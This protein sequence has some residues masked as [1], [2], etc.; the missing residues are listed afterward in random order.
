MVVRIVT[1]NDVTGACELSTLAPYPTFS[2][3]DGSIA[4]VGTTQA[5]GQVTYTF[6]TDGAGANTGTVNPTAA[7]ATGESNLYLNTATG[8]LFGWNGLAWVQV[9][10]GANVA[11]G[12]PPITGPVTGRNNIYVNSTTGQISVWDGAAWVTATAAS[13]DSPCTATV[14]TAAEL[15]TITSASV[16]TTCT[17][18]QVRSV[19]FEQL[20]GTLNLAGLLDIPAYPTD[21]FEYRLV[22]NAAGVFV[23]Q[24]TGSLLYVSGHNTNQSIPASTYTILNNWLTVSDPYGGFN[25]A[26]GTYTIPKG[27]IYQ[28]C[29]NVYGDAVSTVNS[30]SSSVYVN[31]LESVRLSQNGPGF[32]ALEG[33]CATIGLSAGD[34]VTVRASQTNAANTPRALSF[35]TMPSVHYWSIGL[36]Q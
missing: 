13:S 27:G 10:C 30:S 1:H 14:A 15:A 8:T 12:A 2:S 9:C 34:V 24:V 18:G 33:G 20:L 19:T 11:A 17:G 32:F 4:I 5:S 6:Q 26:A 16:I 21:G 3:P 35:V 31:G 22:R 36:A 25:N 28:I 29:A 23:W 7:P